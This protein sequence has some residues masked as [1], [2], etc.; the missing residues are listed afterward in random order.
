MPDSAIARIRLIPHPE[1]CPAGRELEVPARGLLIDALL[2]AGIGLEHACEKSCA[3]ATCHI[4]LRSGAGTV[5]PAGEQEEDQIDMAWGLDTQSRLACC[6]RLAP[7]TNLVV[8]L[9]RHSR[10]L[11]REHTGATP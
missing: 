7:G 5:N 10:N 8:E 9:P 11:A 6:V 4:H 1:F 3:C 2:Q